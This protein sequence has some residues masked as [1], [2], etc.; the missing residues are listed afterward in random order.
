MDTDVSVHNEASRRLLAHPPSRAAGV[1]RPLPGRR[2]LN[3]RAA[4]AF[5]CAGVQYTC[6]LS[7]LKGCSQN[8]QTF[9]TERFDQRRRASARAAVLMPLV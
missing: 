2:S 3:R 7:P 4:A 6:R 9:S 5:W 1:P 8:G